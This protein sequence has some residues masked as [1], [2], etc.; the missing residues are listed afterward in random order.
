V[1]GAVSRLLSLGL[2]LLVVL[3]AMPSAALLPVVLQPGAFWVENADGTMTHITLTRAVLMEARMVTTGEFKAFVSATGHPAPV[4]T[5]VAPWWAG[6]YGIVGPDWPADEVSFRDALAYANWRSSRDDLQP[7]YELQ[8]DRP[9]WRRQANGWRLPTEAEWAF[10]A[11][12]RDGCSDPAD[13]PAV[14]PADLAPMNDLGLRGMLDDA[15]EWCWDGYVA[16]F[17]DSLIDP[18]GEDPSGRRVIRGL[19]PLAREWAGEDF[20]GPEVGFR[21]VR[22]AD[23]VAGVDSLLALQDRVVSRRRHEMA[24]LATADSLQIADWNR[25]DPVRGVGGAIGGAGVLAAIV[26]W[27][28]FKNE[29]A[30]DRVQDFGLNLMVIGA[31]TVVVGGLVYLAAGSD[32]P[33][34]R[35]LTEAEQ[36]VRRSRHGPPPVAVGLTMRF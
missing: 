12:C 32:L 27:S 18:V 29:E 2:G 20:R 7:A 4:D 17:P 35:A 26:G 9:V 31:G 19:G 33:R 21:L 6:L 34:E 23:G 36:L 24:V 13:E 5:S 22:W 10:G 30:S 15:L 28:F 14:V 3:T 11:C 16:T 25:R 8:N 1:G